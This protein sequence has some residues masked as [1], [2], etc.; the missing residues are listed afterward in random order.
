[1]LQNLGELAAAVHKGMEE[2]KLYAVFPR[3]VDFI[4]DL[5]KWYI[6]FHRDVL[7]SNDSWRSLNVLCY[8]LFQLSVLMAPY[9][10]FFSEYT[11]QRLLVL[12]KR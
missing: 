5:T 7:K 3:V 8:L 1:M 11:Y 2:Y 9:A 4:D 12:L 6:R 10:P